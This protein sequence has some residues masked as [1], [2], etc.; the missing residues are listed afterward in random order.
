MARLA[1]AAARGG[2]L[3]GCRDTRKPQACATTPRWWHRFAPPASARSAP[4]T[5]AATQAR[6]RLRAARR[7]IR[8]P[9]VDKNLLSLAFALALATTTLSCKP[10]AGT[11]SVSGTIETDEAHL[12]SR[13]GGRVERV[14][15]REGEVL[16][17]G[18]IIVELDAAELR[19]RREQVTALL[20]ELEAGPRPQE[21][22]VAKAEWQ[23]QAA[24]L[25]LAQTDARRAEELFTRQTLSGS[26]HDQ[27]V[28]RAAAM[29]KTSAAAKSRYDLLLAGTRPERI[30]QVKAQLAELDTQLREMRVVAP[31]HCVL[32]VLSVKLG[33]VVA[34]SR[35]VATVL[36]PGHTFARVF[37]PEPWLG[38]IQLGDKVQVRVD[39][40]PGREFEGQVE[41]IGRAAEFT[42]RNVQT[43]GERVKQVFPIKVRLDASSG[44]L[45]AG[46]AVDVVFPGAAQ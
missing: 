19:A 36:F 27:A 35:E 41:F 42:P 17:N 29:A 24:Q 37:V 6:S 9:G 28:T 46:M 33:D 30:A 10:I 44:E 1:A 7:V 12:A 2:N 39:A 13:Y 16:T 15:A 4:S 22:A 11:P 5:S 25:E 26:E 21:I 34:P 23:A 43:V 18:Q 20:A 45:R 31:T 8:S 40:I 14:F 38:R 3:K 32:E